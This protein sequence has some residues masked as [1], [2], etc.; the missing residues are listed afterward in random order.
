MLHSF[1][2]QILKKP[3]VFV[4]GFGGGVDLYAAQYFGASH[5]KAVDVNPVIRDILLNEYQDYTGGIFQNESIETY[6]AEGRHFISQ[7]GPNEKYDLIQLTAVDTFTALA[8]GAY[9]VSENY[10]YTVEAF[11]AYLEH[12]KPDGLLSF[13]RQEFIPP[14]E[15][16]RLLTIAAEAHRRGW[17]PD[18]REHLVIVDANNK[19]YAIFMFKESPYTKEEVATLAKHAELLN[20]RLLYD[21]FHT[22]DNPY[23]HYLQ[24]KDRREFL[25]SYRYDVTPTTDNRPYFFQFS[26]LNRLFDWKGRPDEHPPVSVPTALWVVIAWSIEILVLGA[27]FII[28]PLWIRVREGA[29]RHKWGTVWYFSCLGIAFMAVELTLMQKMTLYLGNPVWA[30]STVL[31]CLLVFSGLGSFLGGRLRLEGAQIFMILGGVVLLVLAAAFGIGVVTHATLRFPLAARFALTL[32]MIAPLG[33]LMGMPF[34]SG[35][36]LLDAKTPKLIPIAWGANAFASTLGAALTAFFSVIV[37]FQIVFVA[38]AVV[39]GMAAGAVMLVKSS[40]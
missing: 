36:R 13:I 21:P 17:G 28:V 31:F 22:Y 29:P 15:T 8:S 10:L 9:A 19:T 40:S 27:L 33:L 32:A 23:G 12:L 20:F 26:R 11:R 14:R 18:P 37:G 34:P 3:E 16:M 2:Y 38:A 24:A 5:T 25:D 35:I 6:T 30:I 1:P 7:M 39:Y 4:V